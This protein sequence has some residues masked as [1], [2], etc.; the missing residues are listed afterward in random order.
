MLRSEAQMIRNELFKRGFL[1]L[2][3]VFAR[4]RNRPDSEHEQAVIR[5]VIV[6]LLSFYLAANGSL[7]N[8]DPDVRTSAMLADT[9]LVIA[10][11]YLGL[12]I[13]WPA[14]SPARRI[15]SMV[16]DFAMTSAFMHFGGEAA[17][18]FYAIYLWVA[19]G[20]GFRYGL[21]YLAGSGAL[22]VCG[23]LAVIL[24][25]PFWQ[26]ESPLGFGLLAA[27][28]VLPA[29][30]A[31]L[32]RKLREAKAQ[33]EAASVAKSRF[34]ATMSHELRTPLNAIIGMGDLLGH[35]AL[36]RDQ[37]EMV[38][39]IQTSGGALLSLI[40][41]VLDV[42][43][44]EAGRITVSETEFDLYASLA[45]IVAMFRP[46]AEG[47]G[48]A[49]TLHIGAGVPWPVRGDSR[50]LRQILT[51]L[52]AN[53]IKFTESG[54]VSID[55]APAAK[56]PPSGLLLRFNVRDTGIGIAA[57]QQAQIFERFVQADDTIHRRYGGTGL[58]LSIT[59]SLVQLVGGSIGLESTPGKGSLF[60]V[61]LPFIPLE[62]SSDV[63]IP[64]RLFVLSDDAAVGGSIR[65][66]A[67]DL[68]IAIAIVRSAT[69][70]ATLL[71]E[72]G[73]GA[74]LAD[75]RSG[76]PWTA[77][78]IRPLI[79]SA[80]RASI[81]CVR[82]VD[83][84]DLACDDGTCFAASLPASFDR[85]ALLRALHAARMIG[86]GAGVDAG[87]EG[88]VTV[89]K[90]QQRRLRLLVAEDNVINQKV[91]KRILEH[92]GHFVQLADSG[93]D[94]LTLLD[95]SSFD[96]AIVDVNMP[97]MSGLEMVKLHRMAAIGQRHLPIVVLSADATAETRQAS[98]DAGIDAYLTKPVEPTSM[99][100]TVDRL[101]ARF[102]REDAATAAP[103]AAKPLPAAVTQISKHPRYRNEIA[104]AIS[105]QFVENLVRFADGEFVL[106]VLE[107]YA[108]D[109]ERLFEE[110]DRAVRE[111]DTRAFRDQVHALRGTSGNVG[112]ES[113][114]RMCQELQGISLERLRGTGSESVQQMRRELG[115]F[116]RELSDR[117]TD[118]RRTTF[119]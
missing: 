84:P 11:V 75:S 48:L 31:S 63:T 13:W 49:L 2:R 39:T 37:Q 112:A 100:G 104:P 29:Y 21:A 103:L 111:S 95:S 43:Q 90:P 57:E 26:R 67:G 61:D 106:Q 76:R 12:I 9:Y 92:A 5:I 33:A 102:P 94:A 69:Q 62:E 79:D 116:R 114:R 51:N 93:E 7:A 86:R 47:K 55:V 4:F 89:A 24:T 52:I 27:L 71:A 97:G 35:T 64:E 15:A 8:S 81:V 20:N 30:A 22:A 87:D 58:G 65:I 70:L 91:T 66:L 107:E 80:P 85:T 41:D 19:F 60:H 96:L 72:N 46:Q 77:E 105:W 88:E 73:T 99:L 40:E 78:L 119:C 28:V 110:M 56:Q 101:A 108:V 98:Y 44:I 3:T 34:L 25:T 16:T 74:V 115:R 45:D 42:S 18:P 68:P 36:D 82:L 14:A 1:A 6:A 83:E 32:I 59:R 23:F 54:R 117:A 53:A 113:M 10:C 17:A 50:H 109:C 38:R 118:L